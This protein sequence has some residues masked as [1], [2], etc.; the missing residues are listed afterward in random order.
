MSITRVKAQQ[1]LIN[2]I[3]SAVKSNAI[4]ANPVFDQDIAAQLKKERRPDTVLHIIESMLHKATDDVLFMPPSI[5]RRILEEANFPRQRK[6]NPNRVKKHRARLEN[7]TWRGQDFPITFAYIFDSSNPKIQDKFWLINGQHRVTMI[8]ESN[9]P[10][11]IKVHIATVKTE[12]QAALLYTYFDDPSES[13]SDIEVLDA[14]GITDD[15][16]VPRG[17]V[18]SAYSALA[19]LRNDLEPAYYQNEKGEISRDREAR[20][21]EIKNWESEI[22]KYW[23]DISKADSYLKRKLLGS[24]VTAFALYTYRYKPSH[25]H[26]FW[27]GIATNDGLR[28][29]DPRHRLI[30]DFNNRSISGNTRQSIQVCSVAWNAFCENREISIIKIFPKGII[31]VWGTPLQNGPEKDKK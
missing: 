16:K 26:A 21:L 5:A 29:T 20:M 12:E 11:R 27:S 15:L 4:I 1:K 18:R 9:N 19:I 25:A 3:D 23:T 22:I 30:A 31:K 24:G 28:K 10:V 8:A 13:R 2:A 14:R 6:I 17:I 7:G